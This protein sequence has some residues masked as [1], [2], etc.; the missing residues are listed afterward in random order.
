MKLNRTYWAGIMTKHLYVYI[1]SL[2]I[3]T[4]V[5]IKFTSLQVH[6]SWKNDV[7]LIIHLKSISQN[8]WNEKA[9]L[10]S[11]FRLSELPQRTSLQLDQLLSY[12]T[13]LCLHRSKIV[14]YTV[15]FGFLLLIFRRSAALW[16]NGKQSY[17]QQRCSRAFLA[18]NSARWLGGPPDLQEG[19]GWCILGNWCQ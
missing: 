17:M 19:Y 13:F 14:A 8:F 3:K 9:W 6:E 15:N 10:V 2:N 7:S 18:R 1:T 5:V 12:L 11:L 4:R 16:T